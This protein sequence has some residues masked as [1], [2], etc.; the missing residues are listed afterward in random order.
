MYDFKQI[1]LE[2]II[3]HNIGNKAKEE[4]ILLSQ[5]TLDLD[6]AQKAVLLSYYLN[7]FK[8]DEYYQFVGEEA[9]DEATRFNG[10]RMYGYIRELY[11]NPDDFVEI[12][13]KIATYLFDLSTHPKIVSG[14]LHIVKFSNCIL[15]E[16]IVSGIG[17]FKSESKEPF[18]KLMH[19]D[20]RID[21]KRQEGIS[22]KK[23][24]RACLIFNTEKENGY[25]ILN[26]DKTKGDAFSHWQYDFLNI[27]QRRENYYN[28]NNF[29]SMI[30]NFSDEVLVEEN[31]IQASD[32]IAFIQRT[33]DYLKNT[34]A[35][36][37]ENFVEEVI[38]DKEITEAFNN[39]IPN[40]END[41]D[42]K[43]QNEFPISK[44][45][46]K[47]NKKYFKSVIKLDKSFHVYVHTNPDNLEKG[48]DSA[49]AMKY[50]KL[51]YKEEE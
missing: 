48:F 3:I 10:N 7:P 24:D 1:E 49:R 6:E 38:G 20:N 39:Y 32:Q 19:S 45:A 30:K 33:E 50:Y 4:D 29:I 37:T 51:Y 41:Y 28:T 27:Q 17:F 44:Q 43:I 14:E 15:D 22:L 8:T 26:I 36:S 13:Q 2:D 11:K 34:D 46:V 25:K 47:S 5:N 35:F 12:S 18:I 21:V 31:N 9:A 42:I 23:V 40:F 16:E